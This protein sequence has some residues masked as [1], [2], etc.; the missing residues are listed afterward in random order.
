MLFPYELLRTHCLDPA[1]LKNLFCPAQPERA[2]AE[3]V[4]E[5]P[6]ANNIAVGEELQHRG[7]E[8]CLFRLVVMAHFFVLV[9]L[10]FSRALLRLA[11]FRSIFSDF[12]ITVNSIPGRVPF[13]DRLWSVGGRSIGKASSRKT[14]SMRGNPVGSTV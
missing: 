1:L 4:P 9:L 6:E 8:M 14:G 13:A 11:D 10:S 5:S 2:C 7:G 3:G 12:C